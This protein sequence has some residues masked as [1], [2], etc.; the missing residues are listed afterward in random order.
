[1]ILHGGQRCRFLYKWF[2][3]YLKKTALINSDLFQMFEL[4]YTESQYQSF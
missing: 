1:M 3:K 4:F 2:Q